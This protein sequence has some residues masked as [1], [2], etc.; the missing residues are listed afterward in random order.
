MNAAR[1]LGPAVPTRPLTD[2][3]VPKEIAQGLVLANAPRA[4]LRLAFRS[5]AEAPLERQVLSAFD[6]AAFSDASG[7]QCSF[8]DV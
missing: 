2:G 6:G 4:M 1:P 8:P 5:E 7:V 3:G